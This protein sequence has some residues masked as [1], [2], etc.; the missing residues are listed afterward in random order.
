VTSGLTSHLRPSCGLPRSLAE[1]LLSHGGRFL[2]FWSSIRTQWTSIEA[3]V[4]LVKLIKLIKLTTTD[5]PLTPPTWTRRDRKGLLLMP[6]QSLSQS[7]PAW[8]LT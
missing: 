7:Y 6:H 4:V 8:E 2:I 5:L 3:T 1:I